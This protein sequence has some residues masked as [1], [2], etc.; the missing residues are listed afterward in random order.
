M[1]AS[2]N[3]RAPERVSFTHVRG[4]RPSYERPNVTLRYV[5]ARGRRRSV[6]EL[7]VTE[8]ITVD[9]VI[10]MAK[11]WFDPGGDPDIDTTDLQQAMQEQGKM[12]DALLLGRQTFEDS[13]VTRGLYPRHFG[14][15]LPVLHAHPRRQGRGTSLAQ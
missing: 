1:S 11:G 13:A 9:G 6:R 2:S 4:R 12:A 7:I 5:D 15:A 10:D 3:A 14:H 8:N